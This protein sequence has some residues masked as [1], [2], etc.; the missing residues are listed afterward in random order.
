MKKIWKETEHL[1]K[2]FNQ[3]KSWA[4]SEYALSLELEKEGWDEEVADA[5]IIYIR[6]NI[7]PSANIPDWKYEESK[8]IL[9]RYGYINAIA[10]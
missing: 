3:Y 5:L 9:E 1:Q 8:E 7:L 6:W 2:L 10:Q 4:N